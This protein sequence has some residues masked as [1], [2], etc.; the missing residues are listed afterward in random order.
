MSCL[1]ICEY[2]LETG[3]CYLR[4][5]SIKWF[6]YNDQ[7]LYSLSWKAIGKERNFLKLLSV[8]WICL[9]RFVTKLW[10]GQVAVRIAVTFW[11]LLN[12]G[13]NW[14]DVDNALLTPLSEVLFLLCELWRYWQL[15]NN[16]TFTSPLPEFDLS[17][18]QALMRLRTVCQVFLTPSPSS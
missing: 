18:K 10:R 14:M 6:Y 9:S 11:I 7:Q 15:P 2:V 16:F 5:K 12:L 4:M 3:T 13:G 1:A 8:I 17:Q